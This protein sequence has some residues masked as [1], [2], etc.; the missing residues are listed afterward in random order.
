VEEEIKE[1]IVEENRVKEMPSFSTE[2]DHFYIEGPTHG[3][4]KD[5]N[6]QYCNYGCQIDQNIP[7]ING[8]IQWK[9]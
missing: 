7:V 4:L 1:E 2:C 9:K 3:N 8:R 6:C 5:V